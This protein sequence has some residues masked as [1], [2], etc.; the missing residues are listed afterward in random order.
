MEG[1]VKTITD[2]GAF[3]GL[4]EGIDGLIHISDMSWTKHV[5]NPSDVLKKGQKIKAVVLSIDEQ[6]ERISLGLKQLTPDPWDRAIPERYKFGQDET[7]KV[8]K[9]ADFGAFVELEHGIEGLIPASEMVKDAPAFKEGD[10]VTARVIKVDKGDRK[11]AL[12][13]KAQ[14]KG[15]D[16]ST[17]K[18]YM[19]Q[20][21][22][23]DTSIG[24]LLK[25]RTD[26]S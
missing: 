5:K 2:F 13:V 6:K 17:L 1:K 25:E 11:I 3:I 18:D 19:S 24:A 26:P 7:V 12:S 21:E 23:P 14:I 22:K 4:E 16:R 15:T 20:Q 10:E 9:V 8:T